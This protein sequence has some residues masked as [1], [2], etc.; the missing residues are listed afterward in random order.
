MGDTLSRSRMTHADEKP[1][2]QAI[3]TYDTGC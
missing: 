1:G 2:V 3:N